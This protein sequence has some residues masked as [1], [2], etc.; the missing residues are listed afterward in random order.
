MVKIYPND[1]KL[2]NG[3]TFLG[4]KKFLQSHPSIVKA[5][6]FFHTL[7][8]QRVS[9]IETELGPLQGSML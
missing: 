5:I 9:T 3:G 6:G 7:F 8:A 2:P 4:K 1:Q